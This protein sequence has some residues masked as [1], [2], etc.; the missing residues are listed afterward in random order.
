MLGCLS[1]DV[2]I[3][4]MVVT[5]NG[6]VSGFTKGNSCCTPVLR[7][8]VVGMATIEYDMFHDAPCSTYALV[9]LFCQL[10]IKLMYVCV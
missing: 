9:C 4:S 8:K 7:V 10:Q 6:C 2:I 3:V 1:V 5:P